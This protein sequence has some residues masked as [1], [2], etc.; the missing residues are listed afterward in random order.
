MPLD[1]QGSQLLAWAAKARQKTYP[2]M[3]VKAARAHYEKASKVLDIAP[4]KLSVVTDGVAQQNQLTIA[5]RLY[6]AN[7]LDWSNPSAC[8]LFF[9]GG[10]FTI[11]SL[12]THDR[13]CRRLASGAQCSVISIDYRLAPEF[14]FPAAFDDAFASLHWLIENASSMG[15]DPNKIAVAGDSAGGTLAAACALHA[16]DQGLPLLAQFLIYPGLAK[17]KSSQSYQRYGNGYLLD[18]D[19]VDWFFK[20]FLMS[21]NDLS[22]W[23]FAPL[24][25]ANLNGVA[26]AWLAL[27]EFDP[28]VDDGLAYAQRLREA[29][30]PTQCT[31]YAGMMHAF[32]QHGGHMRVAR[33]AH[34]D[35]VQ[36][37]H[38]FGMARESI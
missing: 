10:G 4:I 26:P 2:Q 30:V 7:P 13:L 23:R 1:P 14:A 19:T 25:F 8:L 29:N 12:D 27:A 6:S 20:H 32:F 9:H 34:E 38:A 24:N 37:M 16:R 21:D 11:G 17:D 22:D 31:N 28:L 36:A 3:G 15:I 18:H 35:M 5:Y 33:Q